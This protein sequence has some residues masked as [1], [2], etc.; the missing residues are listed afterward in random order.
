MGD[1]GRFPASDG[2][3]IRPARMDDEERVRGFLAELS[4][5]TQALRF[6]TGLGDPGASMVRALLAVDE[7]RDALLA[8][9]GDTVVGHAMS[10]R[11]GESDVEIAVV[12]TDDWQGHGLGSRL[13]RRLLRR[14]AAGGART[15]GMDVLGGNRKVLSMIRKEWPGAVMR[16]SSG[17]VEV[18]TKIDP[19]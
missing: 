18:S 8:V 9:C 17:T 16:V 2:V 5:H 4:P 15:V 13:V 6:F 7:R 14:A 19:G 11:G 3:E 12:V 1:G 10:F